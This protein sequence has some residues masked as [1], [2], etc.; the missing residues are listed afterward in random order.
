MVDFYNK[1]IKRKYPYIIAEIGSNH[2]GNMSLARKLID[3]AIEY[4]GN[5]Y[6]VV[7]SPKPNIIIKK[8]KNIINKFLSF[9]LPKFL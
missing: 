1:I 3:K 8:N 5:K 4:R 6:F 9:L 2:N 7:S